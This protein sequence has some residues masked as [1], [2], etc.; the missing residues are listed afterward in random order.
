[1][2]NT[3]IYLHS[4]EFRKLAITRLSGA[5][6]IP[7]QSYDDMGD[8]GV[9]PRWDVFDSFADYL[10]KTFPLTHAALQLEKVNTHGLL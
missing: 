8:I 4:D 5:V 10:T 3:E 2:N 6:Q 7:T 1:M 9:D